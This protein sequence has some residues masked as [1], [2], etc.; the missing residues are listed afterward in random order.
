M[1]IEEEVAT[2]NEPKT[3]E[4]VVVEDSSLKRKL[5]ES[6][7][8]TADVTEGGEDPAKKAKSEDADC[9]SFLIL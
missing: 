2:T 9:T 4:E 1:S 3:T 5:D 6:E 8:A 7:D